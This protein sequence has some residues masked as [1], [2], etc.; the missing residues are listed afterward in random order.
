MGQA[1]LPEHFY[2]Q[3]EALREE[4]ILRF[5]MSRAPAWGLA[6]LKWDEFQLQKGIISVQEMTLFLKSGVLVD[7]PGN[8]APAFINLNAT[9]KPQVTVY[10]HLQSAYD[11][12]DVA[13]G[14][15]SEDGIARIVQKI[16]LSIEAYSETAAESFTLAEIACGPDGVWSL[17]PSFVPALVRVGAE[18]FF[19]AYVDR[20]DG[21]ARGLRHMLV[22][23]LEQNYLAAEGQANAKQ[24][25][26]G[27]FGF[28]AAIV[29]LRS[30][31][32][33]HP[34]EVFRILREVYLDVCV[35]RGVHA[36]RLTEAYAHEDLNASIGGLLGEL[37]EQM[38]IGRARLPYVEFEHRD[39]M[40]VCALGK[41][42][43][44][45]KDVFVLVQ[46]PQI[47]TKV[48]MSRVKFASESR[49]H[50]VHERA[51]RGIPFQ[52]VESPSFSH[53]LSSSVEFY[54]LSPGQE[55]DYAVSEGKIV[56]FESQQLVG[57][58]QY[59]YW[60]EE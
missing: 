52:R 20:M 10:V 23:E 29:D 43:R 48:D 38:Q 1:L 51:L 16:E 8:T 36:E 21:I 11:T 32:H 33:P 17:K 56:F 35:F 30:E 41:E 54:A 24:C 34:Y 4:A 25:L 7:I 46:K 28:Q 9:G 3:E 27:L 45:A 57:C 19:S 59:L 15:G 39:G 53:G 14:A 26:R 60:R 13:H 5:R 47:A 12:V 50:S 31:I 6:Q 40:F 22:Q 55:W 44:R 2:A 37:E 49:I 18:P 42:V 58:R